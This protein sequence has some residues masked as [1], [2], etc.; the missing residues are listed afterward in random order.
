MRA[1]TSLTCVGLSPTGKLWT[2]SLKLAY[3]L[4]NKLSSRNEPLLRPGDRV[5][6]PSTPSSPLP[7]ERTVPI[8]PLYLSGGRLHT[9]NILVLV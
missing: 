2:R 5:S 6:A 4:L 3:T 1:N 9:W 7:T 8:T